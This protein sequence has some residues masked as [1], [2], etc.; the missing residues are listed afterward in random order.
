MKIKA[1]Y[2][3]VV[4]TDKHLQVH[5]ALEIGGTL[6]RAHYV[7]IPLDSLRAPVWAR[8]LD[9]AARRELLR[10]WAADDN[11]PLPWD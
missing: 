7:R 11:E 2:T 8:A 9:T 5:F 1:T 10:I 4:M 6:K 3:G